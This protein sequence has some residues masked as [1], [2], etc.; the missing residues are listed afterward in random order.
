[1]DI[2]VNIIEMIAKVNKCAQIVEKKESIETH[3]AGNSKIILIADKA[4]GTLK[5][6]SINTNSQIHIVTTI[7]NVLVAEPGEVLLAPNMLVQLLKNIPNAE[8]SVRLYTKSESQKL[9][10]KSKHKNANFAVLLNENIP[11]LPQTASLLFSIDAGAFRYAIKNCGHS[12]SEN[13]STMPVL[14]NLLIASKANTSVL[15]F[16]A[17]NTITM[18]NICLT[19]NEKNLDNNILLN[20]NIL[21][22]LESVLTSNENVVN[23]YNTKDNKLYFIIGDYHIISNTVSGKYPDIGALLN[24]TYEKQIL[25]DTKELISILKD[26]ATIHNYAEDIVNLEITCDKIIITSI[27]K[28]NLS[29]TDAEINITA[30]HIASAILFKFNYARLLETVVTMSSEN[31]IFAWDTNIAPVLLQEYLSDQQMTESNN[32]NNSDFKTKNN[33]KDNSNNNIRHRKHIIV[34]VK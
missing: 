20:S 22:I 10:V 14:K 9:F 19:A 28:L 1:M 25:I 33:K 31:I 29:S 7:E 15:N 24:R 32:T 17:A 30:P 23:I 18:S 12:I 13:N 26:I 27:N 8:N 34:P 5:L 21:G 16:Y 2:T 11:I 3:L 6:I 4:T